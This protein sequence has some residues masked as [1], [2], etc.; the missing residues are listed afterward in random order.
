MSKLTGIF[1]YFPDVDQIPVESIQRWLKSPLPPIS[2]QNAIANRLL[3]PQTLPVS[4]EDL[5]LDLAILREAI[6][7]NI[8]YFIANKQLIIPSQFLG[9]IPDLSQVVMA[10]I[11]AYKYSNFPKQ[12]II[13]IVLKDDVNQDVIGSCVF[14]QFKN[15]KGVAQVGLDQ[16]KMLDVKVGSLIVMPCSKNRCTLKF[17]IKEGSLLTLTTGALDVSGGLVGVF[18]DGRLG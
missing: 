12:H 7:G 16:E 4:K 18:I 1:E 8:H 17:D 6:R 5:E 14:I 11:D 9:R 13:P 10:F 3:Y 2:L 15:N